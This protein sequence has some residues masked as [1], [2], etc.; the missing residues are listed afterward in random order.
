[1]AEYGQAVGDGMD[2]GKLDV[3]NYFIHYFNNPEMQKV[4]DLQGGYVMYCC[5]IKSMLS[6]DKKYIFVIVSPDQDPRVARTRLNNLNWDILQTRTIED[7]H[8]VPIHD[9]RPKNTTESL[10]I[11]EKRDD[12]YKYTCH[13]FPN[14]IVSMLFTKNQTRVYGD[15]GDLDAAIETYNTIIAFI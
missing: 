6:K 9:Y 12:M 2:I 1:M 3:Y 5:K 14:I 11:F 15:R 4:K 8:N 7:N 13:E 10:K